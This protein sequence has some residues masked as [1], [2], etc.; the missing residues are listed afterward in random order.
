M[1]LKCTLSTLM[2]YFSYIPGT[3]CLCT[4]Y[5]KRIRVETSVAPWH[6]I[7]PLVS[8]WELSIYRDLIGSKY[9]ISPFSSTFLRSFPCLC[10]IFTKLSISIIENNSTGFLMKYLLLVHTSHPGYFLISI[11]IHFSSTLRS[12]PIRPYL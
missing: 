4:T 11:W 9:T 10:A 1:A 2:M 5:T 3:S 6:S 12:T 8:Q 7:Y